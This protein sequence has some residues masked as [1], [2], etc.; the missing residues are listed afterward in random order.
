MAQAV[1]NLPAIQETKERRVGSQGWEDHM[2]M[3]NGSPLQ[4]SCLGS[5]VERGAWW[6]TVHGSAKSQT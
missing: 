3:E 4:Y 2:E 6:A 1:K 5:S